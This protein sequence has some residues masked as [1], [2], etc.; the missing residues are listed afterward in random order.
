MNNLFVNVNKQMKTNIILVSSLIVV[1]ILSVI[2][3][4]YNRAVE[5]N[6][7]ICKNLEIQIKEYETEEKDI[8][9]NINSYNSNASSEISSLNNLRRNLLRSEYGN[10]ISII[11]CVVPQSHG[12]FQ[13]DDRRY[14]GNVQF[15]AQPPT[16]I[17]EGQ[18]TIRQNNRIVNERVIE[19]IYS[20]EVF[21]NTGYEYY[22]NKTKIR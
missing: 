9:R 4:H 16:I 5:N 20:L 12:L 8:L 18:I 7:D 14:F 15:L 19:Y 21:D 6:K 3:I 17:R 1:V 13:F 10:S 2:I 11:D 22:D